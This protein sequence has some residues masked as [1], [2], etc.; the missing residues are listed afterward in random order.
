MQRHQAS[1]LHP[2]GR[3]GDPVLNRLVAGQLAAER[4]ALQCTL[5]EH[6]ERPPRLAQPAHAV[7][8]A[9]RS[10]PCLRDQETLPA[11]SQ[12]VGGGHPHVLLA[13]LGMAIPK[14]LLLASDPP[15]FAPLLPPPPAPP[16]HPT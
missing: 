3:V 14:S 12:H 2:G 8:D 9:A 5:A 10:E 11:L 6:F 15:P 1:C 4:L 7:M 13:D 16:P